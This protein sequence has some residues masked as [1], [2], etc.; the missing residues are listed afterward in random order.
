MLVVTLV[1]NGG[2]FHLNKLK[3]RKYYHYSFPLKVIGLFYL[4]CNYH[5]KVKR[6]ALVVKGFRQ[7]A[8]S[9]P[10]LSA[11]KPQVG[12]EN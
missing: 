12:Q 9:L 6:N 8:H 10:L 7:K 4:E 2:K 11:P 5:I 3:L 1:Q